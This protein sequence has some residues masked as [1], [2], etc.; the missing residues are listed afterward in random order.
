MCGV[1]Q[2]ISLAMEPEFLGGSEVPSKFCNKPVP[3]G[4][5]KNM[6][7]CKKKNVVSAKN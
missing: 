6:D 2:G 5:G 1:L 3:S 7:P 4:R